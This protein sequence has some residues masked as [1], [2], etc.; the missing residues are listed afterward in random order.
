M[1][2]I[3]PA[4]LHLLVNHIPVEGIM[5]SVLLL[6]YAILRNNAELKRTALLAFVLVGIAAFVADLT[7]DGAAGVAKHI[8]GVERAAI[9][10]HSAAADTARFV[11][12]ALAAVSLLG[13]ILAWRTKEV[14]A[15]NA[16]NAHDYVRHHKE[17]HKA[18]I[19]LCLLI[20]LLDVYFF[21]MTAYK[22]GLIRHPEIESGFQSQSP[23]TAP[24]DTTQSE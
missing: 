21:A 13:L 6:L 14:E 7:G 22:G 19:I 16:I 20:G 11:S 8:P 15:T 12:Y 24:V 9:S 5:G 10:A 17:P 23:A 4:H 3:T 18:I 2:G 1:F